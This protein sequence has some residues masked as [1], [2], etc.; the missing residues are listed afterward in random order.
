MTPL[1]F[2]GH[3]DLFKAGADTQLKAVV[4]AYDSKSRFGEHP[5]DPL[6]PYARVN[7][8]MDKADS[9]D[10]I[11][12]SF[13]TLRSELETF[14]RRLTP[15]IDHDALKEAQIRAYLDLTIKA[16]GET[17]EKLR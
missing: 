17:L 5:G 13:A 16:L 7:K 8:I 2:D 6:D 9:L 14:R 4:M 11:L 1:D 10:E 3:D 12:D 15:C